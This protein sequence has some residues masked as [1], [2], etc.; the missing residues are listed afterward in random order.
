MDR[1]QDGL[2]EHYISEILYTVDACLHVFCRRT[3]HQYIGNTEKGGNTVLMNNTHSEMSWIMLMILLRGCEH[4]WCAGPKVHPSVV[5]G[6][7][8][9]NPYSSLVDALVA[10]CDSLVERRGC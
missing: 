7:K 10:H 9:G 4:I 5:H 8:A 3:D 6:M 1:G 2:N